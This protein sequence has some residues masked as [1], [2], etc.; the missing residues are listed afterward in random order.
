LKTQKKQA[1]ATSSKKIQALKAKAQSETVL[2]SIG[3]R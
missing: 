1:I 3:G 2:A